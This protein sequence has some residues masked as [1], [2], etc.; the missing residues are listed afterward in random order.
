MSTVIWQRASLFGAAI[1]ALFFAAPVSAQIPVDDPKLK[2]NQFDFQYV[3]PKNPAHIP[4]YEMKKKSRILE[5]L[6]EFLSPFR[7]RNGS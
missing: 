2:T 4:I 7:F 1:S 5:G 6:Q 3:E